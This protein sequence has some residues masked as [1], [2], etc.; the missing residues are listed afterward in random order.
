MR[1]DGEKSGKMIVARDLIEREQRD[2]L[3]TSGDEFETEIRRAPQTS[4]LKSDLL[5][6]M[7]QELRALL[8][9][10]LGVFELQCFRAQL[11]WARIAV[12]VWTVKDQERE[13]LEEGADAAQPRDRR[14]V[15]P[16]RET[17]RLHFAA[18]KGAS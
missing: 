14:S 11:R 15:R 1:S 12:L 3:R 16:S 13:T 2:A 8:D 9:S 10:I 5:A 18:R 7:S 17:I 4:R 6:N